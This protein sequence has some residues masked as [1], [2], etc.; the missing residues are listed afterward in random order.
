[1][2]SELPKV[3]RSTTTQK[4]YFFL[5]L[6][7]QCLVI[8]ALYVQI[9]QQIYNLRTKTLREIMLDPEQMLWRPI[10][11]NFIL[12]LA[13]TLKVTGLAP[14]LNF[15]NYFA[16]VG[17][18]AFF[19]ANVNTDREARNDFN[20]CTDEAHSVADIVHI[21][22][23]Q[24]VLIPGYLYVLS[25]LCVT[26]AAINVFLIILWQAGNSI[27]NLFRSNERPADRQAMRM[28]ARRSLEHELIEK[29]ESE[30]HFFELDDFRQDA[31][32][33]DALNDPRNYTY[34]KDMREYYYDQ[35]TLDKLKAMVLNSRNLDNDTFGNK[36][37]PGA[38]D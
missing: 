23:C 20:S 22:E 12:S 24:E 36:G 31:D 28:A 17:L 21:V 11:I 33:D 27:M 38:I 16:G 6:M 13:V 34:D 4:I 2:P 35:E 15:L 29:L 30:G 25:A 14:S 18:F 37:T 26:L 7:L 8:P 1:M 32:L 9:G 5:C 10:M 3:R 19:A